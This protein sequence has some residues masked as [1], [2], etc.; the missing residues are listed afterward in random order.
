MHIVAA[1][2]AAA[3]GIP[4]PSAPAGLPAPVVVETICGDYAIASDGRV[5]TAPR[6]RPE[7][8]PVQIDR[9][10]GHI[11]VIR[12]GKVVWRSRRTFPRAMDSLDSFAVGTR[13][14]AF[15]FMRGRLWVA[16]LNGP[17]R[18]VARHEG[19]VGWTSNNDLL[20]LRRRKRRNDI[21]V[22]RE[23]GS[24][25]RL[26]ARAPRTMWFDQATARVLYV[27]ASASLVRSDGRSSV[28]LANL[29]DLG[30]G[31]AASIDFVEKGLIALTGS[32]R[33]VVLRPDG[34]VFASTS[35]PSGPIISFAPARDRI[36]FVTHTHAFVL[37]EGATSATEILP[38]EVR[39]DGCGGPNLSWH[40]SWLL[41]VDG[42]DGKVV[43]LDSDDR[44]TTID[45]GETIAR[46]PGA[47]RDPLDGELAGL[48]SVVWA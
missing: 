3:C 36:A 7:A 46:L 45:L 27:T 6:P 22:R 20:T 2:A 23:G 43:A 42:F 41:Y 18:P 19:A 16:R 12:D 39:I 4:L 17:E 33:L 34:S 1:V 10:F 8:S 29:H 44:A 5:T 40:D 37:R 11:V 31:P 32:G 26:V 38:E 15:S 28:A 21:F 25:P 24:N 35:T 48:S 13:D 14:V 30:T 47:G 9:R